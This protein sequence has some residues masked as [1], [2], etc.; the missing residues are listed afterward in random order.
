MFLLWLFHL[1]VDASLNKCTAYFWPVYFKVA[2]LHA[3]LHLSGSVVVQRLVVQ[4][5]FSFLLCSSTAVKPQP[6]SVLICCD[7]FSLIIENNKVKSFLSC[8]VCCLSL[9]PWLW[10]AALCLGPLDPNGACVVKGMRMAGGGSVGLLQRPRGTQSCN[11]NYFKWAIC[12]F[13]VV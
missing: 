12:A 8:L 9:R 5:S 13:C 3:E 7:C 11:R 10:D 2:F 4:Y 6:H 1:H